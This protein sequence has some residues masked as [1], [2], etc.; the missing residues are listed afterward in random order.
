MLYLTYIYI[1]RERESADGR[2]DGRQQADGRRAP[3]S[4]G[5]CWV[6]L[7]V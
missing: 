5:I 7:L 2:A 4:G 6:A 1:Y 3:E